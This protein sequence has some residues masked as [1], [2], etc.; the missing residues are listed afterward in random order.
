MNFLFASIN[1]AALFSHEYDSSS[2]E[3][4]FSID[5]AGHYFIEAGLEYRRCLAD[6][7]D[8][9]SNII[10]SYFSHHT[11]VLFSGATHIYLN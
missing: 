6:G 1:P 3:R 11:N 2:M 9:P 4:A 10:I 8:I 7:Q 5:T